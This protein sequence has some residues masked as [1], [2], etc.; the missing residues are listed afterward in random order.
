MNSTPSF[1]YHDGAIEGDAVGRGYEPGKPVLHVVT[2]RRIGCQ[3]SC[4]RSTCGSISMPLCSSGPIVEVSAA[5]RRVAPDLARDRAGRASQLPCDG[6]N[7]TAPSA[8]QSNFLTFPERQVAAREWR[9]C[10]RKM[11][12]RLPPELRNHRIP[13][14]PETPA[15]TAASSLDRPADTPCQNRHRFSRCHTGGRPGEDN[16]RRVDRSDFRL[17]VTINTSKFGVLRRPVESAQCS[18]IETMLTFA[19]KPPCEQGAMWSL[20]SWTSS[21]S[22]LRR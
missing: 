3:L 5:C 1:P 4:L 13:T 17:P 22:R 10:R 20:N 11:C 21:I 16:L 15:S 6:T 8:F 12:R 18:L 2:K 7:A 19:M 14:G 9:R